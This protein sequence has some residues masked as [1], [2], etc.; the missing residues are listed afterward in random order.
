MTTDLD[1]LRLTTWLSPSF[2]VGAFAYSHGLE[3]A[4]R[5]GWIR[6]AE[7]LEAWIAG[8]L[9]HGAGWTDA[10]LLKAAWCSGGDLSQIADL[11]IAL[12]PCLE[13]RRETLDQGDAF[14]KAVRPW[15]AVDGPLPYPVAVGAA[16]GGLGVALVPTL[17]A[18]CHGFS[19][20]LVGVALRA[21][22]LGQSQGVAVIHRLEGVVLATAH[23]A[24]ASDLDDLGACAFR[25]DIAAM[26][27]ETLDGRLFRS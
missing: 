21:M 2:P 26:R 6:D 27:H 10:V 17:T 8:L 12:S 14:A 1:L 13:R 11:A 16:A 9:A 3:L 24:G 18:W 19:A 25:A 5:E 20:N 22:A 23:R 4:I 7:G 15:I